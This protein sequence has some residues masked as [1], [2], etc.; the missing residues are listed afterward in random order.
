L[1]K[2]ILV[3]AAVLG[4]LVVMSACSGVST[5]PDEVALHYKGGSASSAKFANCVAASDR[6]FDGP[7]DTHY[8]YPDGQRTFSFTGA[9]G[10]EQAPVNVT[11]KD[12]QTLAVPGFVTFKLNTD[13]DTLRKFHETVGKKYAAYKDGKPGNAGWNEF[14][15]DYLAVP[16]TKAMN[17]AALSNNWEELYSQEAKQTAFEKAVVAALPA[18]VKKAL[19]GDYLTILE[20]S[21]SKPTPSQGLLDQLAQKEQNRLANLAQA[22]KNKT[23]ATKYDGFKQCRDRGISEQVCLVMNLAENGKIT[24]WPI[25]QGNGVVL[26]P[27]ATK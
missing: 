13:C 15:N 25:P 22:E 23:S 26:N 12:S 1:I 18:S 27:P 5:E 8:V 9:A 7:G 17:Q 3:S 14:L 21:I 4:G 19:G 11:T 6:N 10:S 20:V 24:L 2:K 16:L